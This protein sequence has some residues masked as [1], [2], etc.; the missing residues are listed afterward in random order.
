MSEAT[1]Q[2]SG[3]RV[4]VTRP[5]E[6]AN[7]AGAILNAEGAEVVVASAIYHETLMQYDRQGLINT[8]SD[9]RLR[10]GWLILP[11]PMA[12]ET[13]IRGVAA[14]DL[15]KEALEGIAVAVIGQTSE[16]L[17]EAWGRFADFVAPAPN[18]RALAETLPAA[19]G[20]PIVVAGAEDTRIELLEG[21]RQRGLRVAHWVLYATR[22]WGEGLGVMHDTLN[23][24]F[25]GVTV[26]LVSS[27]SAVNAIV[28]YFDDRLDLIEAAAWLAIGP[29]TQRQ[30]HLRELEPVAS[31]VAET[32]YMDAVVRAAARLKAQLA[33]ARRPAP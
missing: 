23:T 21:L 10:R 3:V 24:R 19:K 32:P 9:L 12:V 26:I 30:I 5:E 22:P 29:T 6:Q 16:R 4:I 2:L 31:I 15:G 25:D 17:L 33:D 7:L 20:T 18:G 1:K 28:D 14:I 13:F 8:L 11:S 27:P